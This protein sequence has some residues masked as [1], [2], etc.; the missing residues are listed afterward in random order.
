M[1]NT[2][3]R[4]LFKG[5]VAAVLVAG[6][7]AATAAGCGPVAQGSQGIGQPAVTGPQT[8]APATVPRP[9]VGAGE[10]AENVYDAAKAKDWQAADAPLTRSSP[11]SRTLRR[12]SEEH[13]ES[14]IRARCGPTR[15]HSRRQ[16]GRGTGRRRC[17]PPTR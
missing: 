4:S 10:Y 14:A 1:A 9:L 5:R 16:S 3:T 2:E 13:P 11:R 7:L 12:S 17:L 15:R 6:V 8:S